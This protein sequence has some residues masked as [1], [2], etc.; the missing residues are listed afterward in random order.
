MIKLSVDVQ[1][2]DDE[3]A[4]TTII[5]PCDLSS[6]LKKEHNYAIIGS[7]PSMRLSCEDVFILNE[8][9]D[10]INNTNPDM[11]ADY[12]AFILSRSGCDLTDEEFI[13]RVSEKEFFLQDIS[14]YPMTGKMT[15]SEAAAHYLATVIGMPFVSEVSSEFLKEVLPSSGINM[16]LDW[17][18]IWHAY[19]E[20]GFSVNG[21][22]MNGEYG[23][24]IFNW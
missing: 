20:M 13:R 6:K 4:V 11:T 23:I 22:F 15:E 19:S 24:F 8:L 1:D 17:R 9:L 5:L 18:R 16:F 21:D 14:D 12:L 3:Y 2:Y 7:T 10:G